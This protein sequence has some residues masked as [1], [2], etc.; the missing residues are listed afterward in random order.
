[1]LFL[2]LSTDPVESYTPRVQIQKIRTLPPYARKR[3]NH[4]LGGRGWIMNLSSKA[5][6]AMWKQESFKSFYRKSEPQVQAC[7]PTGSAC[8]KGTAQGAFPVAT[9]VNQKPPRR[10][11]CPKDEQGIRKR[12]SEVRGVGGNRNLCSR[13]LAPALEDRTAAP[14]LLISDP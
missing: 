10:L 2:F 6:S 11:Q 1:M 3:G 13:R 5:Q 8:L 14:W 12:G 7:K 9:G 4:E